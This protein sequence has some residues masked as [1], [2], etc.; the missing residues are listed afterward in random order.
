MTGT[1]KRTTTHY[2]MRIPIF[3]APGWGREIERNLDI[4]DAVIFAATNFSL[5]RGLWTNSTLY[6]VGDRVVDEDTN[7]IWEC[8]VQHTSPA[9]GSFEDARTANPTYWQIVSTIV[10]NRGVW[11]PG[12]SYKYNDFVEFGNKV[13]VTVVPS[14]TS[15]ASFDDDVSNGNLYVVIDLAPQIAAASA[16][17]SAAAASAVAAQTSESNA[18]SSAGAAAI[19]ES[20]A[21]SSASAANISAGN[22]SASAASASSSA[23]AASGSA[24]AAAASAVDASN[25]KSAAEGYATDA[26]DAA[27]AAEATYIGFDKRYLGEKS[28]NP[29]TDNQGQPLAVGALYWNTT[30]GRM[31]VFDGVTWQYT[32]VDASLF[33]LKSGDTMTGALGVRQYLTLKANPTGN[34]GIVIVDNSDNEVGLIFSTPSTGY[35]AIRRARGGSYDTLALQADG[36][37]TYNGNTVWDGGHK[38]TADQFR[39]GTANTILTSDNVWAAAGYVGLTG[40]SGLTLA[41]GTYTPNFNA[42]F[43]FFNVLGGNITIGNPTNA[44]PGQTGLIVLQQD[45]TGGRTVAFGSAWKFPNNIVPPLSTAASRVNVVAY[46]VLHSGFVT[47]SGIVGLVP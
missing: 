17:A 3:D 46:H 27:D 10:Q 36:R 16:S 42:G 7:T 34:V 1:I 25:A 8:L 19:S 2:N 33:V 44:K 22:A 29:A 23:S 21:A 13:A 28:S 43:N 41:A 40:V 12:T 9:S 4:L 5:V 31:M 32:A 15:G 6:D 11:Q 24:S 14:Y 30:T 18:A 37:L 20:N 47:C 45:G 35:F 38:A 39:A 26:M